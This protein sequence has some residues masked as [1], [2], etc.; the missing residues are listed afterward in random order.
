MNSVCNWF[1]SFG[2]KTW[3]ALHRQ[4]WRDTQPLELGN[5]LMDISW[6]TWVVAF[7]TFTTSPLTAYEDIGNIFFGEAGLFIAMVGGGLFQ[8]YAIVVGN[9]QLRAIMALYG[10]VL[11][12]V[13]TL[14][15]AFMDPSITAVPTYG[16]AAICEFYVYLTLRW[17]MRGV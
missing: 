5:V 9:M 7:N 1:R 2:E 4:F 15:F 3:I 8:L 13:I 11:W 10:A 6:G 16:L 12:T 14:P 17:R